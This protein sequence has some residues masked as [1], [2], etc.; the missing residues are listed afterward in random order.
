MSNDVCTADL[1]VHKHWVFRFLSIFKFMFLCVISIVCIWIG[2]LYEE[3]WG[4]EIVHYG[5]TPMGL[6]VLNYACFRLIA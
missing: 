2:F 6:I 1:I 4:I 3:S 5:I